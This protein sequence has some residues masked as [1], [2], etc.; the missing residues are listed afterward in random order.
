MGRF[1]SQVKVISAPWWA[2]GEEVTIRK[3]SY[4]DRKALAAEFAR[5]EKRDAG[6]GYI[7]PALGEALAVIVAFLTGLAGVPDTG[8]PQDAEDKADINGVLNVALGIM[9]AARAIGP[10][11]TERMGLAVL[12]RG[13]LAWALKDDDGHLVRLTPEAI[14][15]LNETDATFIENEIAQFNSQEVRTPAEQ[16]AFRE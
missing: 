14:A 8:Y 15:R 7:P 13:I 16:A 9:P 5:C 12:E 1:A 3:F 6:D 10:A 11:I 4:G 2:V